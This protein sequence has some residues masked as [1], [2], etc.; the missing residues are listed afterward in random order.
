MNQTGREEETAKPGRAHTNKK[1]TN[2]GKRI[3]TLPVCLH[4]FNVSVLNFLF[5][6]A[7]YS[8]PGLYLQAE[9]ET[10][11]VSLISLASGP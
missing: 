7:L 3:C 4:L 1:K 6:T 8:P 11:H 2:S 9:E 5:D 10:Q